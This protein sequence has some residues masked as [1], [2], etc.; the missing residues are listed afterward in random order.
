MKLNY[1]N[2]IFKDDDNNDTIMQS[3]IYYY[4]LFS[5]KYFHV[6][7]AQMNTTYRTLHPGMLFNRWGLLPCF[8]Y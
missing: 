7:G 3:T 2:K 8:C 6:I 4:Y 1:I 5:M